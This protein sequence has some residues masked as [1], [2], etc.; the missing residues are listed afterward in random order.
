MVCEHITESLDTGVQHVFKEY[1]IRNDCRTIISEMVICNAHDAELV[2]NNFY[3][4][5]VAHALAKEPLSHRYASE[6]CI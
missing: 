3:N 4:Q 1:T 2:N 5:C 6:C